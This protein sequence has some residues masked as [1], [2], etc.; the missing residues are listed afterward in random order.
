MEFIHHFIPSNNVSTD[1][2]Q[3][4]GENMIRLE[5]GDIIEIVAPSNDELH[6]MTFLI[7]YF[8]SQSLVLQNV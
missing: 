5:L 1:V 4:G 7:T 3:T 8:G 6:E 2:P